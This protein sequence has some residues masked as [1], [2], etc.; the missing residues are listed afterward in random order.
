M[1]CFVITWTALYPS[2]DLRAL[3]LTFLLL[4]TALLGTTIATGGEILTNG[5]FE[6]PVTTLNTTNQYGTVTGSMP[7]GWHD[8]TLYG[9]GH[10]NVAYSLDHMNSVAGDALKAVIRL[11]PGFNS[12]I[13]FDV[14]QSFQFVATRPLTASVWLRAASDVSVEIGLGLNQ[15]PYTVLTQQTVN[16]TS[17][18]QRCTLT[19]TPATSAPARFYIKCN[20]QSTTLWLDE[21]SLTTP[22]NTVGFYVSPTGNDHNPGSLGQP[23]RTIAHATAQLYPGETLY[24]RGGTYR[25]T[26]AMSQ[27]GRSGA[28]ITITAYQNEQVTITG[29]DVVTGWNVTGGGIWQTSVPWTL[30]VGTN[31]VFVDGIALLEARTP[32]NVSTNWLNPTTVTVTVT[33]NAVTSTAFGNVAPNYYA[34]TWFVGGVGLSWSWQCAKVIASNGNTLT[35]DPATRSNWWFTGSGRG[36]VFGGRALLNAPNEWYWQPG[37]PMSTL[38]LRTS[39]STN[40]SGHLVEAK[41]RVWSVDISSEVNYVIIRGL[42]LRAGAVRLNG[43]H[44][45]LTN[46]DAKYLS[47]FT[48][49]SNGGSQHGDTEEGGGISIGGNYNA[50]RM[51]IIANTAASGVFAAWE[52]QDN[53]ITR[54][55]IHDIDYSGTYGSP[56]VLTGSGHRVTFNTCHSCGRSIIAPQ[57]I[58]HDIRYNDLF[59]P[60][61]MCKDLGIIYGGYQ[62]GNGAGTNRIAYNWIHDYLLEFEAAAT[63]GV[64]LDN[65]NR[66]FT[67]D[68]NV[69]WNCAGF[70]IFVSKPA[71]HNRTYHNTTFS[72]DLPI[73]RRNNDYDPY[74]NYNPDPSYWTSDRYS[75]DVRNNLELGTAATSQLVDPANRDFRL[76]AGSAAINAGVVLPGINGGYVGAAPD[77]GAYE[78]GGPSWKPGVNGWAVDAPV[79]SNPATNVA[80]FSATLNSS[81]H[82]LGLTTTVHFQ[83][84]TTSSYGLATAAQNQSGN[85]FRNVNASISSLSA[86]TVYHFRVVAT[87]S[88]GRRYGSDRTFTTLGA[89]GPPVVTTNAPTLVASFSAALNGSVDPHGLTTSVHFEYGTTTNYGLTTAPQSQSGN[90]YRSITA[91]I[92]GL[93]THSTY[94]FRTVAMNNAGTTY[95]ADRIFTTP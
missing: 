40:P 43:N 88:A 63:A 24:L 6:S 65:Y 10:T 23:F 45:V 57:G 46:C 55:N 64:Y 8:N 36:Y 20:D 49:F 26:L 75:S 28:P 32:T 48:K 90:T 44:N 37:S 33:S 56:I 60:G 50:V 29:C 86:S 39:D 93:S 2:V 70:S 69:I 31:Q 13:Q 52:S 59:D 7:N 18:W 83:Y 19:A 17:A 79:V 34:G 47:H 41:R 16:L 87:N 15:P 25:E 94:H 76:R 27:S 82:P 4:G 38:F 62:D 68:H 61:L 14:E 3:R 77:L 66:N 95:G 73:G 35:V 67:V 71:D 9:S 81:V 5:S 89:T 78:Y 1:K 58:G 74:P 12:G 42:R 85:T 30:G 72:C 53:E 51:C 21:A 22:G 80:S 54:C 11:E 84:G 91:N 92:N